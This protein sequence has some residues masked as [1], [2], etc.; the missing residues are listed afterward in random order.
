MSERGTQQPQG[1][2]SGP[3]GQ[4]PAEWPFAPQPIRLLPFS[5]W[6]AVLAG[7]A[8]GV[9]LR[10][11]FAG[12]PGETF[13]AMQGSFIYLAPL[14][15]GAVATFVA[16]LTER[17]SW[18]YYAGV[19]ALASLAF[20][21]GTLMVMVE[22]LICALAIVPLFTIF[23][24][25][26]GVLMGAVCRL[27]SWARHTL[28]GL[29]A[30]PLILG[31]LGGSGPPDH[32]A[33][34]ERSLLIAAPAEVIWQ[35]FHNTLA[36]DSARTVGTW[37]YMMGAPEPLSAI[38]Q[39]TPVG[40]V[41]MVR[42]QQGAHFEQQ[43]LDWQPARYARWRY[44]FPADSFPRGTLDDHVRIGG[45]YFDL[46]EGELRM[47]PQGAA[48][49]VTLRISCRISTQFNWYAVPLAR[50]LLGNLEDSILDYYRQSVATP[51]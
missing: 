45:H 35:Q 27:T 12:Q 39:A 6:W 47:T 44:H 30:L 46:R 40:R 41:R 11:K 21:A 26:G 8:A 7:A 13:D 32:L 43:F 49:R 3:G 16:E 42:L 20:V 1:S 24:A 33:T 10:L 34:V 48:T 50:L 36:V 2:D 19:G 5:T 15:T 29:T 37:I 25:I 31:S 51:E 14:L 17:R 28:F 9:C 38:S 22:G 18:G 4:R 23:G